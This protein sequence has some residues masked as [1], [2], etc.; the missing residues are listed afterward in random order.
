MTCDDCN[1]TGISDREVC[2]AFGEVIG[3]ATFCD[4]DVGEAMREEELDYHAPGWRRHGGK[5]GSLPK[6]V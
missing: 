3:H 6:S 1:D 5:N 2:N 4:C